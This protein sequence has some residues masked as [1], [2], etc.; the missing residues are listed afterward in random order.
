LE[1]VAMNDVSTPTPLWLRVLRYPLV[2]L[3]LLGFLMLQALGHSNYYMG[4]VADSPGAKIAVAVGMSLLALIVYAAFGRWVEGRSVSDL[5]LRPAA[6]E[7]AIGLAVGAM[8]YSTCILVLVLAG[9][10]RIDGL[11]PLSYLVPGIAMA[12]SAGFLEELLFRGVLFRIVEEWLGSWIS[13]VVSSLFF[14]LAH[15]MNP[16]ATL[17]SAL[18]ISVEAGLLLA[19]AYMLTRRLWLGIGFHVGWNYVQTAVYSGA[20]S[21]TAV[22]P[23]LIRNTIEGPALLSGGSFGVEAS[24]VA[25]VVCTTTGIVLLRMAIKRG[26]FVPSPWRRAGH[27]P[28]A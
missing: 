10:Y 3:L 5:A 16:E 12:V 9:I 20:V 1:T 21:G 26:H 27:R 8:L 2:R 6:R 7:L 11:N 14:G 22:E 28:S 17:S 15:L 18:F 4:L 24:I 13:I 19:A 23:G 25:F